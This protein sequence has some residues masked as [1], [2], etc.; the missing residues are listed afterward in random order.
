MLASRLS[1]LAR[2]YEREGDHVG[3]AKL[4]EIS[5]ALGELRQRVQA[6][7]WA[8]RGELDEIIEH[9]NRIL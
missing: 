4:Q 9:L 5:V 3:Y 7:R 1:V 6:A 8:F 2:E